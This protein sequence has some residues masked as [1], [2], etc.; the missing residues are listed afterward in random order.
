MSFCQRDKIISLSKQFDIRI[1]NETDT[2]LHEDVA[3]NWFT[4]EHHGTLTIRVSKNNTEERQLVLMAY[5]L[6]MLIDKKVYNP[7]SYLEPDCI[8]MTSN[9]LD[10]IKGTRAFNR[11][12]QTLVPQKIVDFLIYEK[13]ITDISYLSEL[14]CIPE[15]AMKIRL[16][17]LGWL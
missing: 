3:V 17:Q 6:Y 15:N 16:I 2:S 1:L 12:I 14:F 13:K 7:N 4:D 11:A 8:M 10:K 9:W 5:V